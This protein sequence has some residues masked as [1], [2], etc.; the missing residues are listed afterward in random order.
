MGEFMQEVRWTGAF[1]GDGKIRVAY[2]RFHEL[3]VQYLPKKGMTFE[4]VF[5]REAATNSVNFRSTATYNNEK[6]FEVV[7]KVTPVNAAEVGFDAKMDWFMRDRNQ[8]YRMFYEMNCLHCL[9]SFH[10]DSKLRMNKAKLYKLDFEINS[11]KDDGSKTKEVYI[12]TKDKYYAKFSQH[13]L[14]EMAATFDLRQ[15]RFKDF[16]IENM[17]GYMRKVEFNAKEL[18]KAGFEKAG[19][20]IKQTVELTDGTKVDTV[21][22]WEADN[23]Y[24]NKA[25]F[26]VKRDE[27]NFMDNEFE[28][29]VQPNLSNMNVKVKSVGQN[30][31]VGKFEVSSDYTYKHTGSSKELRLKDKINI[32]SSP[33]PENFETELEA[34]FKNVNDFNLGAYTYMAGEKMGIKFDAKNGMQWFF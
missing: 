30:E 4:V 34:I 29:D 7:S 2:K 31:E 32:P 14:E 21:L 26:S 24:K 23:Y 13:F 28:W 16:K 10:V 18:M 27:G 25:K 20:K 17:D 15:T 3:K 8:F 5:D 9:S 1:I 11:V 19:K 12:T 22:T 33:F 6:E